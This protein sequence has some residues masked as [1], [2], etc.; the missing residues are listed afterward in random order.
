MTGAR[1]GQLS[2]AQCP[3]MPAPESH[4]QWVCLLL[5]PFPACKGC[6]RNPALCSHH[7]LA[8][9]LVGA[10]PASLHRSQNPSTHALAGKVPHRSKVSACMLT[11]SL[12]HH[13]RTSA[14]TD[15]SMACLH[16]VQATHACDPCPARCC[17]CMT[18]ESQIRKIEVVHKTPVMFYRPKQPSGGNYLKVPFLHLTRVVMSALTMSA[19]GMPCGLHGPSALPTSSPSRG[20]K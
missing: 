3:C 4:P 7:W 17:R 14:Q 13:A 20:Q 1:G 8:S 2:G 10:Q 15:C 5:L 12:K 11:V 9:W 18:E 16:T 6:F 19:N